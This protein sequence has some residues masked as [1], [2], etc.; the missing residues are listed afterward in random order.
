MFLYLFYFDMYLEVNLRKPTYHP[1]PR[2]LLEIYPRRAGPLPVNYQF[3]TTPQLSASCSPTSSVSPDYVYLRIYLRLDEI[4]Q[5]TRYEDQC[6]DQENTE[7]RDRSI[8]SASS[9]SFNQQRLRWF[10][11]A[12]RFL[13]FF[14]PHTHTKNLFQFSLSLPLFF[15]FFRHSFHT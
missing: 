15:L 14:V 2:C 8:N 10:F 6:R 1:R 7:Q 12:F 3:L 4:L 13:S 11:L 5:Y 9:L